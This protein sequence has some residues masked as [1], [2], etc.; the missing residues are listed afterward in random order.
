[1]DTTVT[2]IRLLVEVY[3]RWGVGAADTSPTDSPPVVLVDPR[4]A[5]QRPVI[6][7]T[8]IAGSL[9]DHL[10][11]DLAHVWLGPEPGE[12]EVVTGSLDRTHTGKVWILGA[13]LPDD[14]GIAARGV[15]A[16]DPGRG[17]AE[18]KMLRREVWGSATTFT[19]AL[20]HDGPAD[21]EFLSRLASWEPVL[22]RGR[23]VGLGRAAV[24]SV[25]S[26]TLDLTTP[27]D[28]TWWLT[29]GA[30]WFVNRQAKAP[31]NRL[32]HATECAALPPEPAWSV[33]LLVA[34]PVHL[35]TGDWESTGERGEVAE[36]LRADGRALIPGAS[37]K[38]LF[39][40]RCELILATVLAHSPNGDGKRLNVEIIDALFGSMEHG[41]GLLVFHDSRAAD[42]AREITRSHVA[43]DRFTG[44]AREGALF[45]MRALDVGGQLALGISSGIP[46]G[47]ARVTSGPV[48]NLLLHVV[49]DL[50][51]GLIGV[52]GKVASGYGWLKL[53]DPTLV[54]S[55]EPV[56]LTALHAALY[57]AKEAHP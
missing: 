30:D 13:I 15:T 8:S 3:D 39:R 32:V 10:G 38:G 47:G 19:L 40:H 31:E 11:H 21:E 41:R 5:V 29:C 53:Q 55:L 6:P 20:Q 7:G 2:L 16:V 14:T 54:A 51:D 48:N 56:D 22:G 17:A 45:Q 18:G 44:G 33:D 34:E 4:T 12:F 50:H 27:E 36:L 46:T 35:G 24:T 49:R 1:M 43:I 42:N 37:W 52:G 9:R 28:L 57:P 23:S 26:V 25:E